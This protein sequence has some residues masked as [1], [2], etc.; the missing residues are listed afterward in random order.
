MKNDTAAAKEEQEQENENEESD[1]KK[2]KREIGS[3]QKGT[4]KGGGGA[5]MRAVDHGHAVRGA[6]CERKPKDSETT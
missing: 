1:F 6:R 2:K 5:V 3:K 4:Q